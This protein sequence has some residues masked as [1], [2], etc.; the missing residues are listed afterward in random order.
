MDEL[1]ER[2]PDII[3]RLN[4]DAPALMPALLDGLIWRSRLTSNGYRRVNYY[5]KHL[6]VDA[7]GGFSKA[8]QWITD[9][10]DAKLVCHPIVVILADLVWSKLAFSSFLY[11]KSWFL[12]NLLVF[13]TSQSILEHM[14]EGSQSFGERVAIFVCRCFIYVFSMGR[15][16][17]GH[18]QHV[19]SDCR[20]K[21]MVKL[22]VVPIPK[23]LSNGQDIASLMLL[24][25]LILMFVN[26]PI[27]WCADN[28]E[29]DYHGNG[30]F[31]EHCPEADSLKFR[32]SVFSMVGMFLYYILI[33]DL[34]VF[35]TRV[36]A[37]TLV[38]GRV[39]SEVVLFLSALAFLILTFSSAISALSHHNVDFAGIPKGAMALL[40]IALGMYNSAHYDELHDDPALLVACIVFVIVSVVFLLNLLIAQL[41]C[42][43]QSIY[44]D[45]LG[46]ARLNRGKIIVETMSQVS[47]KNWS[48]F[49]ASLRLDDRLEFNEGDVGLA[50]GICVTE[51]A[52]LNVTTV[53]M[54]R[55]FG[56]STS[57]AM[58]WPEEDALDDE[59][60]KFDKMEK[61]IQKA[62]KRLATTKGGKKGGGSSGMGN[63]GG[64]SSLGKSGDQSGSNEGS[65]GDEGSD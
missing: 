22:G 65:G 35:S 1:F 30:L 33:I 17:F 64:G 53:D 38:C 39:L 11:G 52:S 34:T 9:A 55:R 10:Q 51:P 6:L 37:F 26:E 41:N 60:D 54:I 19:I 21:N 48:K 32:Y 59:E 2:H 40:E 31:S 43:Y 15:L 57:T 20:S 46:F 25:T 12:F 14:N 18:V 42:S 29:G 28:Y 44:M 3:K 24:I 49:V 45:M 36:S 50:G 7:E 56:G 47:Q 27:L 61:M 8:I 16:L 63:S 13:I 58:Q 62:M 23:Y 4:A 5:I